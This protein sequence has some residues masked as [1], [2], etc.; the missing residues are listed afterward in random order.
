MLQYDKEKG[1]FLFCFCVHNH[2]MLIR[3][4]KKS[5]KEKVVLLILTF[6]KVFLW[7]TRVIKPHH[8]LSWGNHVYSCGGL[9][10]SILK[11]TGENDK[12]VCFL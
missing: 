5:G 8:N 7:A 3:V 6:L 12:G 1:Q 9:G 10:E 2:K 11:N 4:I